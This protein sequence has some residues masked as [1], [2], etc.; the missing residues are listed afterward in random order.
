MVLYYILDRIQAK[1]FTIVEQLLDLLD[2]VSLVADEYS[3]IQSLVTYLL[4]SKVI[5]LDVNL[6]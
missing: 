4:L 2:N 5:H 3:F 6:K 1:D